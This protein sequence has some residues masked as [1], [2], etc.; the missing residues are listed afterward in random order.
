MKF[1][2]VFLFYVFFATLCFGGP[3]HYKNILI[4]DRASTLGGAFTGIADDPS[5]TFYNPAGITYASSEGLSG[6]SNTLHFTSISY[7]NAVGEKFNFDRFSANLLPNYFAM[8][9]KWG[10]LTLGFSYVVPDSTI[11]HQDQ[12]FIELGEGKLR[13]FFNLHHQDVTSMIGPSLSLRVMDRIALGMTFYHVSREQRVQYN[14]YIQS[15]TVISDETGQPIS[16]LAPHLSQWQYQNISEQNSGFMPKIGLMWSPL[17]KFS[18]GVTLSRIFLYHT[19]YEQ[20][21]FKYPEGTAD[22]GVITKNDPPTRAFPYHITWGM[23]Y[24]PSPFLLLSSDMDY[25]L[26]NEKDKLSILNYA[27]GAEYFFSES[28]A[29]RLGFFSNKTNV[30]TPASASASSSQSIDMYGTTLG[31][32]LYSKS[33]TITAGVLYSLGEGK[34]KLGAGIRDYTQ[35]N[36]TLLLSASYGM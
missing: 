24:F 18:F 7:K 32:S 31:Y 27:F 4:G 35:Q 11:E 8:L 29:I 16:L 20:I 25:Y 15:P 26:A 9:R 36:L 21:V 33:S 23:A 17:E 28:H 10:E 22:K 5:G 14:Q 30:P 6:S 12:V 19:R 1:F 34:A 13:Q 2:F 3:E